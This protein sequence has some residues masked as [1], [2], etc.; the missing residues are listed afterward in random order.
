[1]SDLLLS[2]RPR[3]GR[4]RTPLAIT[5]TALIALILTLLAPFGAT[6]A[7]AI[8]QNDD[9]HWNLNGGKSAYRSMIDE[10]RASAELGVAYGSRSS[11]TWY[12]VPTEHTGSEKQQISN[13]EIN[14]YFTVNITSNEH[15]QI[16]IL[17]RAHDLYVQGYYVPGTRT[18][19]YFSDATLSH[20]PGAGTSANP[21][22]ALRLPFGGSYASMASYAH[23]TP[24]S[25]RFSYTWM[26]YN[27]GIL[28][29]ANSTGAQRAGALMFYVEA[30]A[31]GARFNAISD[32]IQANMGSSTGYQFDADDDGLIHNWQ[33][34]GNNLQNRMNNP[35]TAP[36]PNIGRYHFDTL[37]AIASILRLMIQIGVK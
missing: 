21:P 32:R 3:T 9:V 37:Q 29:G 26:A 13:D 12:T 17:L 6:R 33:T 11:S 2:D 25:P 23:Q 34:I 35:H 27:Q 10:V 36:T 8:D 4:V 14:N 15:P 1:M 18:Y 24:R 5:G 19:Y 16:R 20:W 30:I 7:H 28:A 31:E 22:R